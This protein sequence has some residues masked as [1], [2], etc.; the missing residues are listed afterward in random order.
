LLYAERQLVRVGDSAGLNSPV[1]EAGTGNLDSDAEEGILHRSN[2]RR[3]TLLGAIA[4]AILA[5]ALPA[6]AGALV[7]GIS[8]QNTAMFTSPQFL[9]LKIHDVRLV[10]TW[11]V[12]VSR[13]RRAELRADG[14]WLRAAAAA[15]VTPLVSFTGDGNYIPTVS[16][17]TRAVR[18]FILRFPAVKRYTP[19]NEPDW[20]YR[21]LSREPLLAAAYFNA[22]VRSCRGCT[23]L[24][25]D[26]Y[27]PAKQLAPWVRAYRRGLRF[28]PAGWALHNYYDVRTHTTGQLRV[29]LRLTSGPIWL[30]EI[31]GVLRRGH[32]QYHNQSAKAAARDEAFMFSLAARFHRITHIYHYQWQ[33]VPWYGWDSGLIGPTGVPRPAYYV[34]KKAAGA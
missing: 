23:V 11:D 18:A 10:V 22:L 2:R 8:D 3:R 32:W 29:L 14:A 31:S 13:R 15:H 9:A 27:L 7:V 12:A 16:R 5:L 4:A 28:R 1:G 6:A 25:G 24:A 20:I 26:L 33:G 19:W 30:T 21:H 34:L 17:Y